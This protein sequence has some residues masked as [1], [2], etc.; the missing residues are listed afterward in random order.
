MDNVDVNFNQSS[1]N[2]SNL[3]GTECVRTTIE[4]LK[5]LNSVTFWVEG[6]G[7]VSL[8][9]IGIILNLLAIM[10]EAPPSGRGCPSAN[11]P[12]GVVNS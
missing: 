9:V 3:N 1:L 10:L 12:N 2:I 5:Q 11:S 6:V 8:S 7:I 4:D